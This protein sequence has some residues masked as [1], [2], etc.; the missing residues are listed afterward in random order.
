M[1]ELISDRLRRRLREQGSAPLI[2]YYDLATGERTELSGVTFSNWAD[3]TANLAVDELMLDP[4]DQ[5]ELAVAATHPG[6]WVSL[7]WVLA[8]WQIGATVTIGRAASARVVVCGPDWAGYQGSTELVACSLH[9]LGLGLAGS[10]PAGVLDYALEVRG[11]PD[12]HTATPQSGLAPAWRD[13]DRQLS[14]ADLVAAGPVAGRRRLVQPGSPWDT[15]SAA[16]VQPLLGGGST[17]VVAGPATA[18]RLARI[19]TDE[20]VSPA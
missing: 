18:E 20:R 7:A 11:Q 2:T 1:P 6:H 4:G 13:D 12:V 16:L 15:V 19:T 8:C 14:Q 3:K 10:L 5:V 9:P 17:V